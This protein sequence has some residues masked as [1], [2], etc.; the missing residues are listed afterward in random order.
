MSCS[1][2]LEQLVVFSKE[3]INFDSIFTAELTMLYR[4]KNTLKGFT[5]IELIVVI[6]ILGILSASAMPR[7]IELSGDARAAKMMAYYGAVSS[8]ASLANARCEVDLGLGKK[9]PTGG[10]SCDS[11]SNG[12]ITMG[13]VRVQMVYKYPGA[14]WSGID[15]AT[16]LFTTQAEQDASDFKL[17]PSPENG[18]GGAGVTQKILLRAATDPAKCY[19][20]Y[21]SVKKLGDAPIITFDTS[22]C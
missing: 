19:V 20:S 14:T 11:E 10:G 22:G 2:R 17:A 12:G 13:G 16:N 8:A 15:K 1:K 7:F 18:G 5:L 3:K 21:T 4:P 9:A 6:V